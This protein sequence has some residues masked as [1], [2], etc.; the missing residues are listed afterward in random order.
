MKDI[1]VYTADGTLLHIISQYVRL[2]WTEALRDSGEVKLTLTAPHS[3]YDVLKSHPHLL[4]VWDGKFATVTRFSCDKKE[5]TVLA[6]TLTTL[7]KR[8]VVPEDAFT[9][10]GTAEG[11][12]RQLLSKY[13][14]FLQIQRQTDVTASKTVTF[15]KQPK[16]LFEAICTCLQG[17]NIGICIGF[18]KGV[19]NFK[20]IYPT[21]KQ[22]RLSEGNRNAQG[23]KM[24]V[25]FNAVQTAGYYLEHFYPT[26]DLELT[27]GM[28]DGKPQNYMRQ[29]YVVSEI[30]LS[31]KQYH[32]GTYLY[33]DTPDGI[34]KTAATE[35]QSRVRYLSLTENPL[36]V[37]EADFREAGKEI[38]E[39]YLALRQY[40]RE[41]WSVQSEKGDFKPGDVVVLEKTL[42]IEK[43]LKRLEVTQTVFDS[44]SRLPAV[45]FTQFD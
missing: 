37:F 32:K 27:G 18:D 2:I 25:P 12:V 8:R 17:T 7:L 21:E 11:C 5:I 35:Q 33:C 9:L 4:L 40:V 20:F 29:Y 28:A 41:D 10:S 3:L 15:V 26:E 42:G 1:R 45:R 31:G 30:W 39:E 38:A 6:E 19:F 24:A 44:A 34:F 13:A 36:A 43:G 23:V 22:L 16:S 14:P